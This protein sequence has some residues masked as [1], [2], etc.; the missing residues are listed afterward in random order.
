MVDFFNGLDVTWPTDFR[1]LWTMKF[2]HASHGVWCKRVDSIVGPLL[3]SMC[4]YDLPDVVSDSTDS[5]LFPDDA[6]TA[7]DCS[8]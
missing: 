3:F 2:I 8:V 4:V 1:E 7:H 6:F 5:S